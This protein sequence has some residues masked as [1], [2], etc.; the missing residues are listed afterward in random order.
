[1]HFM[2]ICFLGGEFYII[3]RSVHVSLM[4]NFMENCSSITLLWPPY[5]HSA[6]KSAVVALFKCIMQ[7]RHIHTIGASQKVSHNEAA[8]LVLIGR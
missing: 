5:F 2:L 6:M 3:T 8:K 4:K 1:M 7:Y